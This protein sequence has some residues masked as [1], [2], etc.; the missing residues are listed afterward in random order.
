MNLEKVLY[1]E[2]YIVIDTYD[3]A[4]CEELPM[5]AESRVHQRSSGN[6]YPN[7]VVIKTRSKEKYAKEYKAI[8]IENKYIELVILPELGGRIYSAKDKITGYDFFYKQHVIKPAL[9]GALGSWISGGVEFNWP[10]HHRPSTFMPVDHYIEETA[11]GGVIIWLSEHDPIDRMKGMVGICVE[12]DKSYFETR[13]MVANRTALRKSFLWWENTAVPVNKDYEI[14]FPD[15]VDF[16][17]FHY[18]RSA[19]SYPVANGSFNGFVFEKGGVDISKHKNT[20]PATSYFSAASKHDYFGGFDNGIGC[21]VVH[22]GDHHTAV[23]KKMFTWGYNQLSQSWERALTDTDGAYAELMAGSYSDNQP[24][25]SWL[26]PYEVK[27]FS[28]FWYPLANLGVPS[29]ANLKGAIKV[30]DGTVKIQPTTDKKNCKVVLTKDGKTVIDA[31]V[32]LVAGEV[33]TLT[34]DF[35]A[36]SYEIDVEG[37][38]TY[39]FAP[40]KKKALPE[41]FPEVE[42][43]DELDTAQGQYLAG[44]HYLQF[45]DPIADPDVYFKKALEI[46]PEHIPS[47]TALGETACRRND[48]EEAVFYLTKAA[49]ANTKYNTEMESGKIHYLLGYAKSMLNYTEEAY[50]HFRKSAWNNDSICCAMTRAALCAAKQGD[51]ESALFCA[52]TALD[53]GDR[54]PLAAPLAALIESKLGNRENA[55]SRTDAI[56]KKDPLNHLARYVANILGKISDDEFYGALN[57]S[58]SQTLMDVAF[59]LTAGGFYNEASELL[60]KVPQYTKDIAPTLACILGKPELA[61]FAHRTFPF[62]YEEILALEKFENEDAFRYLLGVAHFAQKRY[63]KAAQLWEGL[64]DWQSLRARSVALFREEKTD[65]AIEMLKKAIQHKPDCEQMVYELAYILNLTNQDAEESVKTIASLVPDLKEARDDIVTEW[66]IACIRAEKYEDALYL[67]NNHDFIPCE[68]GE[69]IIAKQH[70]AAHYGIGNRLFEAGRYEEAI[71]EFRTA[72]IIPDNLGAGLWQ[73]GPIIPS[74]YNE[75]LCL[76]H[77]GKEDEAKEIFNYIVGLD[78]DFFSNMHLPSLPCYQTLSMLKLGDS[79]KAFTYL[80]GFMAQWKKELCRK[81]SGYFSATPFFISYIEKAEKARS[82]Y[83]TALINEGQQVLDGTH[84][85]MK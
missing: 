61:N 19:T 83:Y 34:A 72:Q 60:S 5:F 73:V 58:M 31:C 48:F 54:N 3:E 18:R 28:Q 24:D 46:D 55:L 32:D 63:V 82:K 36:D 17:N 45:R 70:I 77:M 7:K 43:P 22:I 4:N 69:T 50:N 51:F 26:E 75:A 84:R 14:F 85:F 9:I 8:K 74:K 1:S 47:L 42:M 25:F 15:D 79:V 27:Q 2:E 29:Y 12:P 53:K 35:K 37:I 44:L 10:F 67:I 66:A 62:R 6:P 65:C 23:G 16:V 38:L 30:E 68:G 81:D 41:L 33:T 71:K 78:V 39:S 40:H 49:T 20:K 57:S 56:L 52:D 11:T 80:K 64:S 59:D 21:G 76:I 13:M